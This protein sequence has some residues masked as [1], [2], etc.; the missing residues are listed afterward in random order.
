V[1]VDGQFLP[2]LHD[3]HPLVSCISRHIGPVVGPP[4]HEMEISDADQKRLG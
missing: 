2:T 1:G 4:R 3:G